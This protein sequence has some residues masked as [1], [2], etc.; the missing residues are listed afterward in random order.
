MNGRCLRRQLPF[1]LRLFDKLTAQD[2]RNL[3]P[4]NGMIYFRRLPKV[5][6]GKEDTKP[7]RPLL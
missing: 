1:I 4:K 7:G 5:I 2:E 6:S 3:A